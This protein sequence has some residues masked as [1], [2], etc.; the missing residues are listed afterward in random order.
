MLL[1]EALDEPDFRAR[2]KIYAT[3][4]DERGARAGA[5]TARYSLKERR[6]R[7]AEPLADA[8]LRACRTAAMSSAR[9]SA[10]P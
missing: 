2:V 6:G 9:T 7:A 1:A 4:V 10:A 8:V 5:A 3:D